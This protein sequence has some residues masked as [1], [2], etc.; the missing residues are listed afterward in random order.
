MN[1]KLQP[2]GKE[3]TI[4]V[5]VR[6]DSK[7][8]QRL[9]RSLRR[10]FARAQSDWPL[11]IIDN[12]SSSEFRAWLDQVPQIYPDLRMTVRYREKNS[13]S[14]ARQ[15][16]LLAC[17]TPWMVYLDSDC[18]VTPGWMLQSHQ[19]LRALSDAPEV[20]AWGGPSLFRGYHSA[21]RLNRLLSS[22]F[23]AHRRQKESRLVAYLPSS[24]LFV[25]QSAATAAGGFPIDFHRA[26]EDLA[27]A[28][29]IRKS[30]GKIFL[31]GA[32][33]ILHAQEGNLLQQLRRYFRYGEAQGRIARANFWRVLSLPFLPLGFALGFIGFSL[34]TKDPTFPASIALL[35][36]L[37]PPIEQLARIRKISW[38]SLLLGPPILVSILS[39]G[40]GT[41]VGLS[42][43]GRSPSD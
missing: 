26:G 39:Y 32:P 25:R 9:F 10:A 8:L 18:L 3:A 15:E 7:G 14:E 30:G 21:A 38:T 17:A 16:A 29:Q 35:I 31:F 6:N 19:N 36:F 5:I 28:E 27:F 24:H 37:W 43:R 40:G 42:R 34:L 12:G 2:H 11:L 23:P 1:S 20:W 4:A 33:N 22:R 41:F 13:M